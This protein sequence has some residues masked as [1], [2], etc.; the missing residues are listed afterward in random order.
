[1]GYTV[2]RKGSV[3]TIKMDDVGQGWRQ[4]FLLLAD[5]HFDSPHCDRQMLKE[6]L[7]EAVAD[8]ALI[9]IIGD[10]LDVM[11]GRNDRRGS[12]SS[13][14]AE[15]KE[16][17]YINRVIDDVCTF[18]EPYKQNIVFI[19]TGNHETAILKFVEYDLLASICRRLGVAKMGYAG[20]VRLQFSQCHGSGHR[21]RKVIYFHHGSV[22]G[23]VTLGIQRAARESAKVLADFY[24][25]GHN[26]TTWYAETRRTRLN[27]AGNVQKD[28]EVHIS[29]PT[30]KDEHSLESGYHIEKDRS[31]RPMGGFILEFFYKRRAPMN[32]GYRVYKVD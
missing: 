12:K 9:L 17:D 30:L 27:D 4:K 6:I 13:L 18:L 28:T 3:V 16:D 21:C 22:G 5:L 25:G 20:F 23:E 11:G 1:M 15:Y 14:K 24:I 32:V 2:E 7:D 19:S 8:G 31:P 26:H 29:I 10:L